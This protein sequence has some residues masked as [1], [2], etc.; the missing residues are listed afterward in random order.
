MEYLKLF[1]DVIINESYRKVVLIDIHRHEAY[2]IQ[3]QSIGTLKCLEKGIMTTNLDESKKDLITFLINNELIFK[4]NEPENFPP[5]NS[6]LYSSSIISNV[7]FDYDETYWTSSLKRVVDLLNELCVESISILLNNDNSEQVVSLLLELNN[8]TLRYIELSFK[9]ESGVLSIDNLKNLF[10][11]N[12]RLRRVYVYNADKNEVL[13]PIKGTFLVT[14]GNKFNFNNNFQSLDFFSINRKLYIESQNGHTYFQRKL[15]I[16]LN[17]EMS[18]APNHSLSYGSIHENK[19]SKI[20][21]QIENGYHK[22]LWFARK[23]I[24]DICKDCEFRHMCVDNRLPYNRSKNEWYHKIECNYNPYI[25]KWRG[26]EGYLTLA[27]CGVVSN[28]HGFSIDHD[29]I[30]AINKEL[31][32]EE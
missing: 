29:K 32:G 23:D 8:S 26:E 1:S 14:Q 30:A 3:K 7:V 2:N 12:N 19:V 24:C 22:K 15:Y 31:W 20:K 13:I 17:G 10:K 9:N 21:E 28:E 27:E 11:V 5:I 6:K 16:A 4:T 25:C 18:N